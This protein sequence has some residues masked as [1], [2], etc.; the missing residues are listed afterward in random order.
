MKPIS[1][2]ITA[3]A[4]TL[5]TFAFFAMTAPAVYADDYCITNGAQTAHGC[6]YPSMEVCRAAS[7]G[8]GG[9]CSPAALA[10]SPSNALGYAPKQTQP[11]NA[12]HPAK[13]PAG[14]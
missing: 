1:K 14:Q 4:A 7:S 2:L 3:P 6:G 8:I 9:T 5:F 10:Q 12:S 13:K 11:R